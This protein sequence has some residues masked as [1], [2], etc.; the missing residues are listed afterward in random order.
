MEVRSSNLWSATA[1]SQR[2]SSCIAPTTRNWFP[3][4]RG[5]SRIVPTVAKA[6]E[7]DSDAT[8]LRAGPLHSG[9]IGPESFQVVI[10]PRLGE[11]HVDHE[12]AIVQQQNPNFLKSVR[13]SKSIPNVHR[14]ATFSKIKHW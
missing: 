7:L 9:R 13:T 2:A 11:E 10:P 4:S 3:D 12:L 14:F 8:C 1:R 5:M 6:L